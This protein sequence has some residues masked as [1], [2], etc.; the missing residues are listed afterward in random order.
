LIRTFQQAGLDQLFNQLT[1]P[2]LR[3][4][5]EDVYKGISYL[6]D[7]DSYADAENDDVVRKRFVYGWEPLVEGYK[8][9]PIQG[10]YRI[11]PLIDV[12]SQVSFTDTNFQTFFS[13]MVEVLVRPWEKM[14]LGMRFTEVSVHIHKS[15]TDLAK[16]AHQLGAIRFDRDVRSIANYLSTQTEFG[17][18]R[19]KF[20]RLQQIATVLNLDSVSGR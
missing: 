7:E 2:R 13:M 14:V 19:D 8:V 15:A 10:A 5:L 3:S 17:G 4:L 20:T 6:L 1:R 12:A 11:S 9:G 16:F 18:S